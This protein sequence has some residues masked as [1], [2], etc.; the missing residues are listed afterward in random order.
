MTH[1][2]R[3]IDIIL[4]EEG[5]LVDHPKDPG[6]L[7]KYGISQRS[8]PALDI[9]QLTR[10]DAIAIYQRDYWVRVKGDQLPSGLDLMVVDM[11]INAGVPRA[12]RILQRILGVTDDG[13]IGPFTLRALTHY[14][15]IQLIN[16]YA[17]DRLD[18]YR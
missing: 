6:G 9:R 15:T 11:A 7:T 10:A 3:C 12:I 16:S 13:I 2:H 4:D 14:P 18:Y 8:Y 17:A 5:G 1:F